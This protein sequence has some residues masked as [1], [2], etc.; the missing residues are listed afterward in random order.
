[1]DAYVITI[2]GNAISEEAAQVCIESSWKK[3]NDFSVKKFWATTPDI[4]EKTL[5]DYKLKWNWP[6]EGE[7]HDMASGLKK[8]AYQTANR[9]ARVGCSLSHFRLWYLCSTRNQPIIV[10]EHDAVFKY[11]LD[12]DKYLNRGYDIIGLNSPL[13]ATR[14]SQVFH[15][16]IQSSKNDL[17]SCPVIDNT[18]IPQGIAGNSAYILTPD[19]AEALMKASYKFGLWPN[20]AIM[21]RQIISNLGVTKKYYTDI[22]RTRSTTTL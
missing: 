14:K 13:G 19:G 9:L 15:N 4:A 6:W 1:M 11:K 7:L 17:Q 12:P 21:C 18:F 16:T 22:Q 2:G 10:L 5:N 3:N 20:D 8:S